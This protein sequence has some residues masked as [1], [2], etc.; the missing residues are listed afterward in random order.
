MWRADAD[1]GWRKKMW[2]ATGNEWRSKMGSRH[3][4]PIF[5]HLLNL[6]LFVANQIYCAKR[7]GVQ[8][9]A[10]ESESVI[11]FDINFCML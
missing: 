1:G 3:W 5:Q 9:G 10:V 7:E 11:S 2:R 4:T 8:F 6:E